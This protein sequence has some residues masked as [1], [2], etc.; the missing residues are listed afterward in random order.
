MADIILDSDSFNGNY[1][2]SNPLVLPSQK[3]LKK[4]KKHGETPIP[5]ILSRSKRKEL[6]RQR[7]E[8][9]KELGSVYGYDA[10]TA[11]T[12][13]IAGNA[14]QKLTSK[15]RLDE[16]SNA[17]Q[18]SADTNDFSSSEEAEP[19]ATES[20]A[21]NDKIHLSECDPSVIAPE[22][23]NS[24]KVGIRHVKELEIPTVP[25][26]LDVAT[27]V[28][29]NRSPAIQTARL[30][31]P[32][33]AE[34]VRI[35]EQIR[36]ND[37]VL[38][39]GATGSGKTT[40]I[41]QF[42][43][44]AGYTRDGYKIGIT[45][46][47]R[48]AAISMSQRVSVELGLNNSEVAYHIRYEKNTNGNTEI[49]FM[50][51]GIL[52]Q[53]MKKDFQLSAYSAI[54]IDEAHERSVYTDILLG[55]LSLVIRLR[56]KAYDKDPKNARLPLKLIIMSATLRVEDFA[57]NRQ[58][59]PTL[60]APSK[61]G[62][63]SN[64]CLEC[65]SDEDESV[66]KAKTRRPGAPPIIKVESRQY[67]VT[68]HFSR[69]TPEDYLK[70]AFRKVITIHKDSP[71]GGILVFLTGQREVKT[72]CSW[73]STAF[74]APKTDK[75]SANDTEDVPVARMSGARRRKLAKELVSAAEAKQNEGESEAK[76]SRTLI[77]I[78]NTGDDSLSEEEATEDLSTSRFNLDK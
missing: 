20:S 37:V 9:W 16:V 45:E 17:S 47:R 18:S 56:R 41:P 35:M 71:P 70:A 73:L 29:V 8:L 54:L 11:A 15:W 59:F 28:L 4:K 78:D 25:S 57:N 72:L 44:E 76:K 12:D 75:T 5:K 68:C 24:D 1:D 58:L 38:I 48:V 19:D 34:E 50:T 55:L 32:V 3:N 33:V 7:N 22:V 66:D 77:N 67:P 30:A 69:V 27:Y 36:E 60:K 26:D 65:D 23:N 31:L 14:K 61:E 39:C 40:Q 2:E 64:H 74:P 63:G 53:E 62:N 51:D 6:Q 46:P 52:L 42:L 10:K 13:K 21:L 43:Y 49:K